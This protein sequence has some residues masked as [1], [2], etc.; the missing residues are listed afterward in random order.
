MTNNDESNI[1]SIST[2]WEWRKVRMSLAPAGDSMAGQRPSA[3]PQ[4]ARRNRRKWQ[5]I[6]VSWRGGSS[7]TWAVRVGTEVWRF[8]GF[9]ALEDVMVHVLNEGQLYR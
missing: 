7:S 5:T 3:K 1:S 2:N 4:R 6:Q 8:D 9:V